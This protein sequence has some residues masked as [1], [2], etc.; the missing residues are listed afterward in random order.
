MSDARR[1]AGVVE[2]MLVLDGSP[3]LADRHLAR[4]AASLRELYGEPAPLS[5]EEL[6][7]LAAGREDAR[8]RIEVWPTPEGLRH[9]AQ[10]EA[11]SGVAE[12][13]PQ[14]IALAPVRFAAGLG[15]HKW[16]DRSGL[17]A[18]RDPGA[19]EAEMLLLDLDGEVLETE[20]AAVVI[21]EGDTLIAAPADRRRL[22]SVTTDE[23]LRVASTSGLRGRREPIHLDRMLAADE[24]LLASAVRVIA[25]VGAVAGHERR[26]PSADRAARL[27]RR[28]LESWRPRR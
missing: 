18:H 5:I 10:I 14:R 4:L 24:V 27:R 8:L 3:V 23:L 15:P 22:R 11:L 28:L 21:V 17:A 6:V 25:S 13:P 12:Q 16:R 20:R 9:R 7:A 26:W 2:T 1:A 19:P